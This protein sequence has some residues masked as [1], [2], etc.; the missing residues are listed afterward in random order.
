M[1][2]SLFLSVLGLPILCGNECWAKDLGVHGTIYDIEEQ[3]ALKWI[4]AR[5]NELQASGEIERQQK[6]M[7]EKALSS[8]HRPKPVAGL[9]RTTNIK[10]F[11]HDLTV[12]VPSDILDADG[13]V[14][15]KA[16]TKVNP[17]L[18]LPT[19]K[20]LLFLDGE[21]EEQIRWGLAEYKKRSELAKLILVNGPVIDLMKKHDTRFY[22]DQWGKL[23]NH[24]KIKQVPAIVEQVGDKLQISE[25]KP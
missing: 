19:K 1:G 20:A 4:E 11:E 15:H 5:L 17:L 22:F 6:K 24:F 8:I 18:M 25:V 2:G 10:Q 13:R 14:I 7:Q 21:D 3:D 9:T 12:T 23:I 16:G